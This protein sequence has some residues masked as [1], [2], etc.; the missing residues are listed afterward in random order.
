MSAVEK[1]DSAVGT[2]DKGPEAA[3]SKTDPEVTPLPAPMP[4]LS[5]E[6]E[7]L[8]PEEPS[9]APLAKLPGVVARAGQSGSKKLKA[10]HSPGGK[11]SSSKGTGSASKGSSKAAHSERA[12]KNERAD[13]N[14]RS[15]KNEAKAKLSTTSTK[16]T[17]GAPALAAPRGN[18]KV[19]TATIP[20]PVLAMPE[21]LPLSPPPVAPKANERSRAWWAI[22]ALGLV[23][24][25]AG[26]GALLWQPAP[27]T[28]VPPPETPA[29]VPAAP[30]RTALTVTPIEAPGGPAAPVPVVE[31]LPAAPSAAAPNAPSV[32]APNTA[33]GPA[34]A[35]E[36]TGKPASPEPGVAAPRT[37]SKPV[38][39]VP[40]GTPSKP[41]VKAAAP[42]PKPGPNDG[43]AGDGKG[44]GKAPGKPGTKPAAV[45]AAPLSLE[46]VPQLSP[47]IIRQHMLSAER[48]FPT[49][50][51]E[52]F[53]SNVSIGIVVESAG[54]V[55][56]ADIL[57]PLGQSATGRCISEQIRGLR[58]PPFTE[59]GASKFFVWSYQVPQAN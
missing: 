4:G 14:D 15:D 55:R 30:P 40:S 32:A 58:F 16:E 33:G 19:E 25:G 37:T 49:C 24:L 23:A 1:Q 56:K 27:P 45:A 53:G 8:E 36:P 28:T 41:V 54:T 34:A 17:T 39:A 47:P 12:E 57:G 51:R 48:R 29:A 31:A 35:V 13:K 9:L 44:A 7:A 43:A 20:P 18:A 11:A 21:T 6:L 50:V 38:A 26:V 52:G 3:G 59:G 10:T 42:V 46:P 5:M 2:G 22:G